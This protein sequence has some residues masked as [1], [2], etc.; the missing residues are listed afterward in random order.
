MNTEIT[1]TRSGKSLSGLP[2]LLTV[3]AC[4]GL[5]PSAAAG[6]V[7][8]SESNVFQVINSAVSYRYQ[9]EKQREVVESACYFDPEVE[10]SMR[11]SWVSNIGGTDP[12]R[13]RQEAKRK[14]T[15][16]CRKAGG[17]SCV[18]FW[19]NGS[20]RF[21][22]L[23]PSQAEKIES[24]L[25]GI[26][27]R[28]PEAR[29]LPRRAVEG[30]R[31]RGRFERIRDRREGWRKK[32]RG[33]NPHWALCASE[34]G[35]YATFAMMGSP[36]ID[37]SEV[38][39]MCVLKCEAISRF[40]DNESR[41]YVVYENGE[42][43]SAATEQVVSGLPPSVEAAEVTVSQRDVFKVIDAAVFWRHQKETARKVVESACYFDPEVGSSMRCAWKSDSG[44][45]EPQ[46]LQQETKRRATKWCRKAGG[47]NCVLFWQNGSLRFD[48]LL[49][50]QAEKLESALRGIAPRDSE[51]LSL[52]EG[53]G[54]DHR[55]GSRFERIRDSGERFQKKNRRRNPHWTVCAS[56]RWPH[57]ALYMREPEIRLSEVREMCV[58]KCEA[59]SRF[60]DLESKCYVV[61]E[62]GEFASAAAERA[63]RR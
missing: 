61:Y 27:S 5:P 25:Q 15:K 60:V 53:V 38:R 57:A 40:S 21:D 46:H 20:L 49:P 30:H 56:E 54:L 52:P 7:T 8:V 17:S 42:L 1:H 3:L 51:A 37:P 6:G 9:K 50:T 44:G 16:W 59:I 34:Q 39:D 43:A 14:A 48:G 32:N 22:G 23:L 29:P 10:D 2:V 31:L 45:G 62:D 4:W 41:C 47:G 13:L 24:A 12:Y 33:H 55:F 19:R 11:C 18:L 36:R 35:A 26:T 58:L 63:L 28:D